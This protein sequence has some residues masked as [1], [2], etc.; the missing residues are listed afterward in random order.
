MTENRL[1][2]VNPD[3]LSRRQT[4]TRGAHVYAPQYPL[5]IEAA[6]GKLHVTGTAARAI[7]RNLAGATWNDARKSIELSLTLETMKALKAAG[8][9]TS[10]QLARYCSPEVMAWAHAA[11]KSEKRVTE[12]HMKLAAGY[13]VEL[14]W[15]D[16]SGRSRAPFEHQTIMA[17]AACM[18]DGVAYLCEMGTAKTRPAI[19][20]AAYHVR[21][22]TLDVVLVVC[23][24]NVIPT[25]QREVSMWTHTIQPAALE[26]PITERNAFIRRLASTTHRA[27][28]VLITNYEALHKMQQTIIEVCGRLRVGIIFDEMHRVRNPKAKMTKAA[29]MIAQRC[30][31]RLGLSGTPIVNGIQNI[32]SQ[33]YVLDLGVTFGA[34][35]VQFR[36]EF[37]DE[38]PYA[39]TLDPLDQTAEQVGLR[40]RRR[41]LRYRKIDCLDLPPKLFEVRHVDMTPEQK[42]AYNQMADTLLVRL[43]DLEADETHTASASIILTMML[44]LA[45]ITSGFL[46]AENDETGE[47]VRHVFD[48]NPKLD[49]LD[50]LV[51]ECVQQG[52]SV[53]VW[54]AYRHDIEKIE[55]RFSDLGAVKFYGGMRREERVD[56]EEGFQSGRY[57]VFVANPASGG[58]G[59]TL[60]RAS[61]A[62]YYSQSYSLEYR[63]QSEDRCHRAG[64]EQHRSITYIDLVCRDSIDIAIRAALANKLE[65]AQAVTE[66]RRQLEGENATS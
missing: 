63:L 31:W 62:I 6:V 45:Q 52:Q 49:A 3:V 35:Y 10:E 22:Q 65:T 51:R 50:E 26:G 59:L 30:T 46:P 53:I 34:N 60:T 11:H 37:F 7:T 4:A 66:L 28:V 41:G 2:I 48:P 58:L 33:W 55:E 42:R 20:A 1:E 32:W 9:F 23:P 18:L 40:I 16:N 25:W 64:S 61:T 39:H 57:R 44:R 56:A 24:A 14:P 29:M 36:R 21:N 43:R 54:A 17:T 15:L 8:G 27:R 38:N 19:E 13:R 47:G 12:M 5:R